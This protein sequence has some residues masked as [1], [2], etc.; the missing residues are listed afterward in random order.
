MNSF[1]RRNRLSTNKKNQCM[2]ENS[3]S[4]TTKII[5]CFTF[6]LAN[7]KSMIIDDTEMMNTSNSKGVG[8]QQITCSGI[9]DLFINSK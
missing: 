5:P 6:F 2:F 4:I 3:F 9:K 7:R 8:V 1:F